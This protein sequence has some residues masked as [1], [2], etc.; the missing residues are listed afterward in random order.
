MGPTTDLVQSLIGTRATLDEKMAASKVS[1]FTGTDALAP[2][3][4]QENK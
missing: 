4:V 2:E 1:M 3:E